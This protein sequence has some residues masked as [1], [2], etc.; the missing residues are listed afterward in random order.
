MGTGRVLAV[1]GA[2][3]AGKSDLAVALARRYQSVGTAAEIVNADSMQLYRGMDIGTAKTPMAERGG[4]VHHLID[5]LDPSEPASVAVV[6]DLARAVIADCHRRNVVPIVVGGS[7]L[8]VHAIL[9][10]MEFP[11]V[12]RQVRARLE[13]DAELLGARVMHARLAEADPVAAAAILPGNLRRIVR[14][15]EV[16]EITGA[17]YTATLPDPVYAYDAV[18]QIGIEL[19]REVLAERIERRVDRMWAAGLIDEVRGL[20]AAG[21]ADA[22]TASRALGYAQVLAF[23]N[24]TTTEPEA[25]LATVVGTRRFARR[26]LSWFRRDGRIRWLSGAA[27]ELADRAWSLASSA[28]HGGAA[29]GSP[30]PDGPDRRSDEEG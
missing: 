21:L 25:R 28:G 22:P 6:R 16:G 7:A 4:V 8:Y 29:Y 3:A 20:A 14:A 13:E 23:L 12:D 24:G 15:L 9:D 10:E 26:Q 17:P 5:V 2:T 19:D 18:L 11:P 27:P 1:V 30:E